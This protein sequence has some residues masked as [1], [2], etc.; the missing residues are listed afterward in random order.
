VIRLYKTYQVSVIDREFIRGNEKFPKTVVVQFLN[1]DESE[2]GNREYAYIDSKTLKNIF[3]SKNVN[4]DQLYI[5]PENYPETESN[6]NQIHLANF[7]CENSFFDFEGT[8][9]SFSKYILENKTTIKFNNTLFTAEIITFYGTEFKSGEVNFEYCHFKAE[10]TVFSK[11]HFHSGDLSFKNSIF[12]EGQKDFSEMKLGRGFL[13]F[14]NTEFTGGEVNFTGSNFNSGRNSFKIARF[15]TGKVDFSRVKFGK[16]ETMFEQTEF[17]NGEVSFRSAEFKNGKVNFTSSKFGTGEKSFVGTLFGNG[18]IVFKNAEFGNG[19]TTFR[20][21]DFG[22]GTVDFHFATFEKSDLIFDYAN[23][24][25]GGIDFKATNFGE[26]K[27]SFRRTIMGNG[28]II[29]QGVAFKGSF[30][31]ADSVCGNGEF[32]FEEADFKEADLTIHNVDFGI[33]KVSFYKSKIRRLSLNGSQLNNYFDL[34]LSECQ[35]LDLSDTVVKDILDIH[36]VEF[37]PKIAELNISGMRLLGRVYL[38]W[39]ESNVKKLIYNQKTPNRSK[40]EQFRI[41][42]ENYSVTGQYSYEDEAYAEFKRTEALAT[43][44]DQILKNPKMK[45]LYY[46][47]YAAKWVIF[48]KMG[49]F[50]TDPLRVLVTMVITYFLFSFVYIILSQFGQA[51]IVSSLFQEGDPRILPNVQRAFYHSIVTF[52][53]IGYGDYYPNGFFRWLSGIEGFVGLFEMS[54][55]TVAFV[56]KILR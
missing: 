8:T 37:L 50:A 11:T 56:R 55:F 18:S 53:T 29:F 7:S 22:T 30:T 34:R 51:H 3:Q 33:G 1:Q 4:L 20:N 42:K 28:D 47:G 16:D 17:G 39:R 14:Q 48:D 40:K 25:D 13:N 31:I 5:T 41:L 9:V 19:K 23:F 45:P 27:V 52:L 46:T 43:L 21:A 49:K 6:E 35:Y 38:D 54:Y 10:K 15:G 26:G 32:N 44:E 24:K 36:P 2:L 12:S